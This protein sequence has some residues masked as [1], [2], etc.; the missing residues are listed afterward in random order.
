MAIS[1]HVVQAIDALGEAMKAINCGND[2]YEMLFRSGEFSEIKQN[3][4]FKYTKTIPVKKTTN[5]MIHSCTSHPE[6]SI[7]TSIRRISNLDALRLL[8]N[9]GDFCFFQTPTTPKPPILFINF[10]YHEE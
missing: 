10:L 1:L 8:I 7:R 3:A 4:L 2:E 9:G 6:K 5:N